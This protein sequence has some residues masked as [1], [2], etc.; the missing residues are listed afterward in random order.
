MFFF[1]RN[2]VYVVSDEWDSWK[3]NESGRQRAACNII[4][5]DDPPLSVR[6]SLNVYVVCASIHTRAIL[7]STRALIARPRMNGRILLKFNRVRNNR[8]WTERMGF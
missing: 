8:R 4:F 5:G 2:I 7:L 1:L 3:Q 6:V